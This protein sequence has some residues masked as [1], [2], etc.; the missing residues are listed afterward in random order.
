MATWD[1]RANELFLKALGLLDPEEAAVSALDRECGIDLALRAEVEC[2]L[3]AGDRAGSF[4]DRPA[5]DPWVTRAPPAA[6]GDE[7]AIGPAGEGAGSVIGP[8]KLLQQIGEGG[9]GSVF[10]AE[11]SRPV[12]RKVAAQ[13]GQGG[14]GLPTR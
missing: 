11:Q 6:T 1:P 13:G 14:D 7:P 3:E 12:R 4:L 5:V 2:L 10:M 8:Y 9:M